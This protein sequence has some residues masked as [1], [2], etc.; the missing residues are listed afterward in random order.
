[1]SK[2]HTVKI[3]MKNMRAMTWLGFPS[4]FR[5]EIIIYNSI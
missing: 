2:G 1:L 5:V 4:E 3:Y